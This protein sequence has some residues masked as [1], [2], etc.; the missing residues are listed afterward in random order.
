MLVYFYFQSELQRV[1]T[2]L[3]GKRKFE[4]V[5]S[6]LQNENHNDCRMVPDKIIEVKSIFR[7]STHFSRHIIYNNLVFV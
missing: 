1:N 6:Q 7:E 5:H 4:N 2:L 3:S